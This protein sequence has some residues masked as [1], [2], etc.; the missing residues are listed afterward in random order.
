M[1]TL[2]LLDIHRLRF[3][4]QFSLPPTDT[5]FQDEKKIFFIYSINSTGNWQINYTVI[6]QE[7]PYSKNGNLD[8]QLYLPL[9][10]LANFT[11]TNITQI[12]GFWIPA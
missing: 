9:C 1:A 7:K 5:F 12:S 3:E 8:T 4:N 10:T 6:Y 2:K 11:T